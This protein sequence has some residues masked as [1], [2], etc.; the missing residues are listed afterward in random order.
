MARQEKRLSN[1]GAFFLTG[2]IHCPY[3]CIAHISLY[4]QSMSRE[5]LLMSVGPTTKAMQDSLVETAQAH[6]PRRI[7]RLTDGWLPFKTQDRMSH[8]QGLHQRAEAAIARAWS[9]YYLSKLLAGAGVHDYCLSENSASENVAVLERTDV[10]LVP[11]GN[12]YQL[13]RGLQPHVA[14]IAAQVLSGQTAYIGESAGAIVAGKTLS[15][16]QLAPAD[17]RPPQAPEQGIGLLDRDVVVHAATA[18]QRIAFAGGFARLAE[19]AFRSVQTAQQEISPF[20]QR[21]HG[22]VT[23]LHDFRALKI[24]GAFEHYL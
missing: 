15:S 19:Y 7:I 24:A 17:L 6:K 22:A 5:I 13:M 1:A 11:G 3:A 23:I 8:A 20:E 9:S 4:K 18:R 10:L 14:Q 2:L 21:A 16:A 12:T